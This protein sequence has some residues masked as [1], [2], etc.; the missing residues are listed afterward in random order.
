[1]TKAQTTAL[2]HPGAGA[3]PTFGGVV[4]QILRLPLSVVETLLAWQ[5]RADQRAGLAA[6]DA[7]LLG[8]VGLSRSDVAREAGLPFWRG[9]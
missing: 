6:L 7:R 5:E 4:T 9:S 8:D 3:Q 1:M 2:H